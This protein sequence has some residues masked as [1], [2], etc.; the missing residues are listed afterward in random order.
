MVGTGDDPPGADEATN[1]PTATPPVVA[2]ALAAMGGDAITRLRSLG[3]VERAA[4]K[5]RP[6]AE[7]LLGARSSG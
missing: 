1:P 6:T 3:H 2:R 5:A 7:R 4:A